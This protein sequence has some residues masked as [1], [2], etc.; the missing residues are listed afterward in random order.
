MTET[1]LPFDPL[2]KLVE[3]E[4]LLTQAT[5]LRARHRET[6]A[7]LMELETIWNDPQAAEYR[8]KFD[9]A[10]TDIESF[11]AG[12]REYVGFLQRLVSAMGPD[13]SAMR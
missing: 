7:V 13:R 4:A 3:A 5:E 2:A 1:A 10:K 8:R 11:I 6:E 9:D 12:S